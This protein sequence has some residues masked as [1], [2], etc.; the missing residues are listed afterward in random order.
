MK[1]KKNFSAGFIT[2][3][4]S[5][6]GAL[7]FASGF[8]SQASAASVF[9]SSLTE[10]SDKYAST[11]VFMGGRA[12]ISQSL[13]AVRRTASTKVGM[14]R[15]ILDLA[16][17][18]GKPFTESGYFHVSVDESKS[19]VVIDIGQIMRTATTEQSLRKMFAKSPYVKSVD[20]TLDPQDSTG[21]IVLN[22]KTPMK[23]EVFQMPGNKKRT[24]RLVIDLKK[25]KIGSNVKIR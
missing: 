22:L 8:S 19:R 13:T 18:D 17:A 5:F 3:A 15:V 20:F 25:V 12:G 4:L 14:E 16:K 2:G 21:T 11:G 23:A 7:S 1:I 9:K 10:K 6:L 24:A